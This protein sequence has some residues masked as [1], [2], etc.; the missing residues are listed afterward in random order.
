MSMYKKKK[1]MFI[2]RLYKPGKSQPRN[3]IVAHKT[4]LRLLVSF[5]LNVY[6]NKSE[7]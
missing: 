1:K 6:L 5:R 2:D 7:L 3:F 4:N